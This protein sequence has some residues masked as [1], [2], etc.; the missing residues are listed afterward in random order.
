MLRVVRPLAVFSIASAVSVAAAL[1]LVVGVGGAHGSDGTTVYGIGGFGDYEHDLGRLR[2]LEKTLYHIDETYV[3]PGRIDWDQMF[4]EALEAVERKVPATMFTREPGGTILSIEIGEHRDVLEVDPIVDRRRLAEELRKVAAKLGEHLAPEDIP[5]SDPSIDP[6]AEIEYT[7]INGMLSTLDPHSVLLPPEDANEM[8]VENQGEFGGLGITIVER[9][10]RLTIEY[11]L[12]NTPAMEAGLQPDDQIVRIDGESTIN[13][14]LDEAVRLLR[15]PIGDAVELHILRDTER[16]PV[17]FQIVRQKI[18]LNKVTGELLEGDVGYVQIK[19][20]HQKVESELLDELAKLHRQAVGGQLRGLVL[21]LRGNPGGYLNQ[22]VRVADAFLDDGTIVSTVDGSGQKRDEE[23]AQPGTEDPYPMAVLVDASSASASEIVAGALRNNGRAVI[24]GERTFGKGSVQ[25]LHNLV[26]D[27]KLKITIS[28]YL[29][30]GDRSI[31]SVGVPADIELRSAMVERAAEDPKLLTGPSEDVALLYYRER[32]RREADLDHHLD[33]V[34]MKV[35][36]PAY[37]V[38]YLRP[39]EERMRV[40]RAKPEE[41]LEVR[42]ARDVL[43]A[44]PSHRRAEILAAVGPV[45][46]RARNLGEDAI[47]KAFALF[48][49][50]WNN[51]AAWPRAEGESPVTLRFD[52]GEDD[53][54]TAGDSERVGLEITNTSDRTLYRVAAIA[55]ENDVLAGR[56]FFFGKLEA[57]ETRRWEHEVTLTDG[58]PSERMP[59]TFEVRDSGDGPLLQHHTRLSVAGRPLPRLEWSWTMNDAS[60]DADGIAEVGEQV[61]LVLTVRNVGNGPTS[62]AFARIKN[63]SGRALDIMRGNVSPGFVVDDSGKPCEPEEPGID[64]GTIYGDPKSE[65]VVAGR[66]V[67]WPSDCHRRLEP[68]QTWTGSFAV[69]LREEARDGYELQ[70]DLGDQDAYD[71]A[72]VVRSGFGSYF[73]QHESIEFSAGTGFPEGPTRKPPVIQVTRAPA[74]VV[75]GPRATISG[76]V[77]D[78]SGIAHVMVFSGADKVFYQGSGPSSVVR[79]VPYTADVALEPGS[80]TVT[81]LTTDVDGFTHTASIVTYFG[82]PELAAVSP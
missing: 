52:L 2:L 51:G 45:V 32:V 67:L 73:T 3:E 4:V 71:F 11:P 7:M 43:L 50:D 60:G 30:P 38:P 21:D 55:S 6:F 42:F 64:A 77:D 46:N 57:G 40:G 61:E 28:K 48:D 29:T 27:S 58:Y 70:L 31:Q 79:S 26:D 54:I 44:A 56:E 81:V 76:V 65:R 12:P 59:I 82:N 62:D 22:A 13:M 19:S 80:N 66:E 24:I 69:D 34:S 33:R 15:G 14:S 20:F 5:V 39:W 63:R 49:V 78:D 74:L 23:E 36:E 75:D 72:S 37:V 41:D 47:E 1:Q 53:V 18:L 25:N 17:A 9:D 68:G 35:E 10:N 16:E 8:D